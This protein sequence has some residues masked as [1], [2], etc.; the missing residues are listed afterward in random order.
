MSRIFWTQKQDIGP[1]GREVHRMA[2]DSNRQRIVLFG[3][4]AGTSVVFNDTWVWDGEYWTQMN[5]L[6]PSPRSA[7]TLAFDSTRNRTVCFA[8]LSNISDPSSAFGDTWEWDGQDW[9]QMADT[10]PA[11]RAFHAMAYDSERAR[12]VIFGGQVAGG[13]LNDTWE[14]DGTEWTQVA[15]T[16]PSPRDA[17]GATYDATRQRMVLFGGE[18]LNGG[19]VTQVGETWEFGNGAWT[20][21]ATTGPGP[22]VGAELAYNGTFTLLFNPG[23][24]STWTWDG[25]HWTERQ[26][27]GPGSRVGVAMAFDSQRQRAVLFGGGQGGVLRHDTWELSEVASGL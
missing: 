12:T 20:Q 13:F 2:Y 26:N 24:G 15:D 10:G 3:G 14:W 18:V 17:C 16:G 21:V 6:G 11:A 1:T 9:T 8:G 7:H 4:R 25:K 5:D 22:I 27:I 19:M 23:D